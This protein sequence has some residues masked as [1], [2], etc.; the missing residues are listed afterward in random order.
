MNPGNTSYLVAAV[1][2]RARTMLPVHLLTAGNN[3]RQTVSRRPKGAA[4]Y[5]FL[6]V[7]K[8][9]GIF[10][11][12][13]GN[14]PLKEGMIVYTARDLPMFYR[15]VTEDF[16]TGWVSY[17]GPQAETIQ[18]YFR[19]RDLA[20][21]ESEAVRTQIFDTYRRVERNASAEELSVCVYELMVTFFGELRQ[22][23]KLPK[24]QR[25]KAFI[26]EHYGDDLSVA[27]MA[28]AAEI[29]ESLLYRIFR[30]EEKVTPVD[31]LRSIRIQK[32]KELL[33][34]ADRKMKIADVALQTGFSHTA[35]FCKVFRKE[36]G[37]TPETYRKCYEL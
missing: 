9:E 30:E 24:L 31:Y 27:D 35:Y 2:E 19:V 18:E 14:F 8:G 33:L 6:C 13:E 29:S 12:P 1:D 26:R 22:G 20:V 21:L 11:S 7:L 10:E 32:A 36:T 37:M 34:L 23:R 25:A 16:R 17:D 4:F 5:Q 3:Y 15:G 28:R